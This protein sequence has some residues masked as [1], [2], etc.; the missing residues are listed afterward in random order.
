MPRA[1]APASSP[2]ILLSAFRSYRQSVRVKDGLV[3]AG[4]AGRCA[5]PDPALRCRSPVSVIETTET[6]MT[7]PFD[8]HAEIAELRAEITNCLLTREELA[9]ALRRL[10]DLLAELERRRR[11]EEGA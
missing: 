7:D 4:I 8:I 2:T 10:E 3:P 6:T 1:A 9:D 5:I 11:E